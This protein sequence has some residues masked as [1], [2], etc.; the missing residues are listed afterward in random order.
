MSGD[1][2]FLELL[3]KMRSV[4]ESKRADYS[5]KQDS[6]QNFRA[7]EQHGV[8]AWQAALYRFNEKVQ[9]LNNIIANGGAQCESMEETCI[10]LSNFGLIL[11]CTWEEEQKKTAEVKSSGITID[12]SGSHVSRISEK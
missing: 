4:H 8:K 3:Q 9:R 12:E 10:D 7:N 2:R 11:L 1:P 5:G 6:W